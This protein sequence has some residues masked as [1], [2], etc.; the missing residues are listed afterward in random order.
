MAVVQKVFSGEILQ[1]SDCQ[2]CSRCIIELILHT[3]WGKK[4]EAVQRVLSGEIL[5]TSDFQS[6]SRCIIEPTCF[7]YRPEGKEVDRDLRIVGV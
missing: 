6:C 7:S 2:S 4:M 5:Q 3:G 1:T